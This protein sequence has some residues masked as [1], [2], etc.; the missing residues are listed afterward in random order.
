MTK[1]EV[2]IITVSKLDLE[3]NDCV[4]DIGAG[5]GSISIEC[6]RLLKNDVYAV[7]CNPL[8]VDLLYQNKAKFAVD[9]L[10][11]IDGMAPEALPDKDITKVIIGG[12]RGQMTSVFERLEQYP[13]KKVVVNTITL[14][15]TMHALEAMK[16]FA[17]QNIDVVTVNVSKG[18][19]VGNVTMMKAE[20]PIT[21]ISG[22]KNEN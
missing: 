22:E 5:T 4:L 12:T 2:R 17:Y 11:I 14:E 20:N 1:E 6:A 8:A 3:M 15:N 16:S 13:I 9:N 7:E 18:H 19:F 10:H 21:I